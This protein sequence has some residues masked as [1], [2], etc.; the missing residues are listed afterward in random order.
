[1]TLAIESTVLSVTLLASEAIG[2]A[3]RGLEE[4][5]IVRRKLP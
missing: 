1:M 3:H 4:A 2:A 5:R